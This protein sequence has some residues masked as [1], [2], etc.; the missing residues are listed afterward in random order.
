[1]DLEQSGSPKG[2]QPI[3]AKATDEAARDFHIL[4]R[5]FA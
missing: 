5:R 2:E 1:M 3:R 4:L